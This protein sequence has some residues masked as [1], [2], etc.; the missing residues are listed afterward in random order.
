MGIGCWVLSTSTLTTQNAYSLIGILYINFIRRLLFCLVMK[1][2][3]PYDQMRPVQDKFVSLIG[4][5]LKDRRDMVLHAPTGLGKTAGVLAPALT[6]AIENNLTVFFLTSRH[7]QHHLAIETVREI[8]K[9]HDIK[10]SSIDIIGKKWM[11][12]QAGTDALFSNEFNEFCKKMRETQACEYYSNI[13]KG[14]KLTVQAKN[15]L[16]QLKG[17][18]MHTGEM[19]KECSH[20]KL[21]PYEMT[22]ISAQGANL[23]VADYFY[24]FHPSVSEL[25]LKRSGISLS[26][27]IVIVD[28]AHNLPARVREL[29]TARLSG[30]MVARAIKE[31][32]KFNYNETIENLSVVNDAMNAMATAPERIVGKLEFQELVERHIKTKKLVADLEF[33]AEAVREE[34]RMS[35]IGGIAAF[36]ESWQGPEEGYAR[37]IRQDPKHIVLT[38]HCLDPGLLTGPIISSAY[39]TILM[40]GTLTPVEMYHDV[41]GFDDSSRAV[42]KSPFPNENRLNLIIPKTTT[43]YQARSE[44][45][46]KNIAYVCSEVTDA[47]PGNSII[48]FPSYDIR[49]QV[50]KHFAHESKK[51]CFLEKSKLTKEEKQEMLDKFRSYNK[52]G[53]VMLAVASGSFA[54]GV[55]LPGDLLKCVVVV[56]LPLSTPDLET[57]QLMD[58]YEKKFK[59]G[60]D[61]GYIFPAFNKALQAAGRCIRSETDRGVV[62]FLDERYM[63]PRYRALFPTGWDMQA[64]NDPISEIEDFF[65]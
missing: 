55:D 28:E 35:A 2:L 29:A 40:S 26:E 22:L 31:A 33:V 21:C 25:F 6:Y 63:W 12:P 5:S 50:Y 23:V 44:Q 51:T 58:Y 14:M 53:A 13:R 19:V 38:N 37:I 62:V 11:C 65:R 61:Y 4:Q 7:T 39:S 15:L 18:N 52:T 8:A 60:W 30:S 34:Q 42:F 56:G 47:V 48:F 32:K 36:F 20:E 54:E 59:K 1:L 24:I 27:S 41:L 9:K 64:S 49:D 16:D 43:K 45:Q 46:F 17:R 10:I 3:F 57:R